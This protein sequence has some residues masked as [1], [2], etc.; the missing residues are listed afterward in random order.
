ML[1]YLNKRLH[2]CSFPAPLYSFGLDILHCS[3]T[4]IDSETSVST[5]R[6]KHLTPLVEILVFLFLLVLVAR[7]SVV[8]IGFRAV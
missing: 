6:A 5:S 8:V 3:G 2:K 4:L 7:F 1:Q